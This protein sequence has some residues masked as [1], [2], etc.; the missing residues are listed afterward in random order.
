MGSDRARISYDNRQQYRSVV[1]Q[2]GRVTVEADWNEAQTIASE[3]TRKEAL[4][5]VG[6]AGTPDNGYAITAKPNDYDFE[7]GPGSMY[8]G[9]MRAVRPHAGAY[10][11]QQRSEWMDWG[12]DTE[13]WVD[14]PTPA[15]PL[16]QNEY[17]YLFLREQEVSGVED[18]DL[19][20]VALGGPDT[21]QRTRLI[22]HVERLATTGTDC[23]SALAAAETAWAAGGIALDRHDM[24]VQSFARMQVQFV[25]SPAS[26]PCDPTAQGGY[27]GADNQLIRVQISDAGSSPMLLWGYDDASFLYRVTATDSHTLTL[28]T[29]PVDAEHMPQGG[30]AVEVL[31][32]GAALSNG[33]YVAA[34][35]GQV[36][37]PLAASPYDADSKTLSLPW[38]LQDPYTGTAPYPQPRQ[39][40]LR[41]WQQELPFTPGTPVT[42]GDT[43]VQVILTSE[44]SGNFRV[45]DYWM[46]AVRPGTP[47][48]VYPE[49]YLV[50]NPQA[51]PQPPDG[52][53]EWICPLAVILWSAGSPTV[54]S[55]RNPFDNLVTLS[56]R[57]TGGCCTV[58]LSPAD[59]AGANTLQTF[60]DKY[61]G[62]AGVNI[63]LAPGAY[64]LSSPLVLDKGNGHV[65]FEACAGGAVFSMAA[66]AGAGP[67]LHG[68]VVLNGVD[69]VSFE[70]IQFQLPLVRVGA[71]TMAGAIVEETIN[72]S[73]GIHAV[74]SRNVRVRNCRF[75]FTSGSDP[76]L[77]AGVLAAGECTG[78]QVSGNRFEMPESNTTVNGFFAPPATNIVA[79][80]FAQVPRTVS[81]AIRSDQLLVSGATAQVLPSELQG[82]AIRDNYFS[83]LMFCTFVSADIGLLQVEGNT[84]RNCTWGFWFL[85]LPALAFAD[86]AA[87]VALAA[88]YA[89]NVQSLLGTIS[90]AATHPSVQFTTGLLRGFPLPQDVDLTKAIDVTVRKPVTTL[91]DNCLLRTV[92]DRF[93]TIAAEVAG[94]TTA[95]QAQATVSPKPGIAMLNQNFNIVEKQAFPADA[96]AAIPLA[97]HLNDNDINLASSGADTGLALF[98]WDLGT[99]DQDAVSLTGNTL[100]GEGPFPVALVAGVSRCMCTGNMVLNEGTGNN[101]LLDESQALDNRVGGSLPSLWLFPVA[102]PDASGQTQV[103]AAA[104]T[105][106]VFRGRA[107]LPARTLSPAPPA[108]MDTWHFF[109]AET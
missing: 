3:E 60:I 22:Q 64:N 67:F 30:Q 66:N 42:L 87:D 77:A 8:V 72:F 18:S 48:Q 46:F 24:R 43:G 85:T 40:F 71:T 33:Q 51:A 106:N 73:I 62:P 100:V 5:F 47:Q 79:I 75:A 97:M 69:D 54:V 38:A 25:P 88:P 109:N 99:N 1:M 39:V 27:L 49:R 56:K 93:R 59:I 20:D 90:A 84:A 55:C 14:V 44:N 35:T 83:G 91:K 19:K 94:D 98:V 36:E 82:A 4:D 86:N 107:N 81:S 29:A 53:R 50:T 37:S 45:G 76:L 57:K 32:N 6:A 26:T 21:A 95:A 15:S 101:P 102:V 31:M 7:I 78:L 92:L 58:N 103:F 9:G 28:Q 13:D 16:T 52:P 41:V 80:G 2:Q 65:H 68:M 17:V 108:P 105:G 23:A 34:A 89:A 104:V 63:C 70:D 96:N 10:S 11:R 74:N 12:V 61:S